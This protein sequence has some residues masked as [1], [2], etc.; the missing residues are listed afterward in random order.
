MSGKT[1][2]AVSYVTLLLISVDPLDSVYGLLYS[3]SPVLYYNVMFTK[4][5]QT[6]SISIKKTLLD[7]FSPNASKVFIKY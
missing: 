4:Y 3:L 2:F 1:D 7:F 5:N 6:I